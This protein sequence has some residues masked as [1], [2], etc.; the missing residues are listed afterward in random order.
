MPISLS[1]LPYGARFV[2]TSIAT[3]D[4]APVLVVEPDS[5][6]DIATLEAVQ[7]RV[8]WLATSIVHHANKVRTTP[9]GVKVGG[10]Q[11]SSASMVS[12]MTALYF[13]H[14]RAADRVSVK[15][16][17]SP[18]LHAINYLLGPLDRALPDDAARVR[19][20]AELS[21]PAEGP[22][23]R[24]L[25]D[26]LGRHRR[27][28]DDLERA[29]A[30]L[31]RRP[32]RRAA[33]RPPGRA[34]RRRRARR[35]RDLGGARRPD[36]AAPRRGA[37]DRRPQPPVA[38]PR[39]ARHRGRSASARCSRRPAGRRSRVKYGRRLREL[40]ARDGG[41]ALRAAHRRDAQRGVP[42]AAARPAGGAARAA[43]GRRRDRADSARLVADLDDDEL[44]RRS[45]ISAGTTSPT[46]STR[47]RAPTRRPTG[48]RSS[49]PTRS[50]P[51]AC[52]RRAIPANH[53]AL[54]S[55]EQWERLAASLGADAADP[56]ARSPPSSPEAALC[57]ARRG[58]L[59][60][61][62]PP[63]RPRRR[64]PGDVGRT[65]AGTASTQQ[66]FGRF[67]VDLAHAA[68]EVASHVVT[69][70]PDVASSTNLG[71]WINRVGIWH[72]GE[73][74]D[75]FADDTDTLVRWR[76]TRARPAHRARHRRGQPRRPARRARRD[77]VARRPAAAADR[78][79]LRPVRQPRARAVV[80]RDV[81]RRAVDPRRHAVGRHAR[82]GGRRAPVDHHAV[83]R[84][85]AAAL[86]RVGA[87]VRAGPRVDAARTRSSRLGRPDGTSAYFRLTH[88]ADRPGAGRR[89]RA[90]RAARAAPAR[91]ARRRLPCCAR[92]RARPRVTLVGPGAVMPEV[93]RRGRRAG[94]G[95]DRVRRRLPHVGRPRVPR[96]AGAAA[97]WPTATTRSSTS[98]SPPSGPRRS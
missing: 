57:R 72:L 38:R 97:G 78:H 90:G 98:C 43:A 53:S 67:F 19:R 96:A 28:R 51:G 64:G 83:G 44:P 89:A 31:R 47:S 35:G 14:L 37:V 42:A 73:R 58:R 7:H 86:R 24:R 12:I 77:V 95:G 29:R 10:H 49:S 52:R 61:R 92:R 16:H 34:A 6:T 30:P 59:Q 2:D 9:S 85:R 93:A 91:R 56:W 20:P 62:E 65:H 70:S 26:G 15:P 27:D 79:D 46:C 36:G 13:E 40:F 69:V 80:V 60:R 48:R 81:R 33:G 23:P 74:I 68:P 75:W 71:G 94:G 54:L 1:S 18:V 39:R 45:A 3:R 50:R 63:L 84:A 76:E 66:A 8:L 4:T 41:D 11:A 32:L 17:A 22:G 5:R 87:G 25:L 88:A 82:A 55:P 21:E